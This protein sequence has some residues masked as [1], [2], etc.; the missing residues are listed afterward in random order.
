MHW[1]WY[2]V[3]E[4]IDMVLSI[5]IFF[6]PSFSMQ[7]IILSIFTPFLSRRMCKLQNKYVNKW[8]IFLLLL[9]LGFFFVDLS[10]VRQFHDLHDTMCCQ[11]NR[12]LD[13]SMYWNKAKE[14]ILCIRAKQYKWQGAR[15]NKES[16]ISSY[17]TFSLSLI[18]ISS[19]C[20]WM[21]EWIYNNTPMQ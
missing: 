18:G 7:H 17:S 16:S 21:Y 10:S 5:R 1:L 4:H 20:E 12:K 2:C 6:H 11:R 8:M 13:I 14:S 19:R 9:H 3:H 15:Q